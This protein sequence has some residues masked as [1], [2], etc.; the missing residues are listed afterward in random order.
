MLD[1]SRLTIADDIR[2]LRMLDDVEF[3]RRGQSLRSFLFLTPKVRR[4]GV[5][6]LQVQQQKAA[7]KSPPTP[8]PPAPGPHKN[9]ASNIPPP[10]PPPPPISSIPPPPPIAGLTD[11]STVPI[12]PPPPPPPPPGGGGPPPPPPPPP[13]G[14]GG[15]PPPPPPPG[16]LA[17]PSNDVKTIKKIYQ[18][19]NKLPQ[20]NWTAM[21]P[22]QAKN[23]VFEKLNDEL[24]IEKIDFSKLEEAFKMTPIGLTEPKNEHQSAIGQVSPGSASSG[25]AGTISARKNTLLDT[26]RLQN[27]AITRRKVAMDAKT[28]MAAVHQLDLQSLSA[29]KVDILSRI[30]PT[31]DERKMYAEKNGELDGLSE[32]DAFVAALCKIERL[33][34]KLTV[35][36]VMAEFDESATLI[37]PQ[38]THVT[39]A[40]KCAREA[41][42]FHGVLEVILAFGNYM[43]SGK[44]GGAYGFK[45]SSLDSL[46]ILKSPADRSLTLLHM[47]VAAIE[48]HLPHLRNFAQ[49]L[50]FV[51][52]ATS[53]QWDSVT[54]DLKELDSGFRM[55]KKEQELKGADCPETLGAFLASHAARMEEM[56]QA[57]NLAK[58]SFKDCVEFYGE[59][60]KSTAPNVFF[61]KLAHFVNN[62]TKCRQENET[63]AALEKRQK[64]EAERR[65]RVASN[66]SANSEQEQLMLELA[67]KVGGARRQRAK[68]DSTR[69]DHGDFEKLMNGLKHTGGTTPNRRKMSKSPSPAPR[70]TAA[71][72]PVA[73]KTR[74]VSVER[75]RQ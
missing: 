12:P 74:V 10:P 17:P 34:H 27:V 44:R 48:K 57:F 60:E 16:S 35:M 20:L 51:D 13:G 53:V 5:P 64:E 63:K 25:S 19:K 56:D 3:E 32:E 30:L 2:R 37:Q 61:Q 18:T 24:I 31:E 69:M 39:A 72:P 1:T 23:T 38:L 29:E 66:K 75:D 45:L 11:K 58:S 4:R 28:I 46:A 42:D 70:S 6:G 15:P 14:F 62:Y 33:E 7:A 47:I 71:P 36:R 43:N 9:S 40:S 41:T 21:K 52:K 65:A 8:P 54:A 59:N 49:Q 68:I 73:P 67:E 22:N 55:A 50:K 26:K